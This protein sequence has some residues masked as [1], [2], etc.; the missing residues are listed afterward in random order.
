MRADFTGKFE[1][2][3]SPRTVLE[4]QERPDDGHGLAV[5]CGSRE[6][7]SA[8]AGQAGASFPHRPGESPLVFK[9][10]DPEFVSTALA[11]VTP[12]QRSGVITHPGWK[13]N[14]PVEVPMAIIDPNGNVQIASGI[15]QPDRS[16]RSDFGC[17]NILARHFG[18]AK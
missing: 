6:M 16:T 10:E 18:D 15:K 8:E 17:W 9:C 5:A 14:Y 3:Q 2:R 1:G 13:P 4:P 11:T 7:Q 12:T